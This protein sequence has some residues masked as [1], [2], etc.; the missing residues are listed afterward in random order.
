MINKLSN[1]SY[2]E[3][4]IHFILQ[5]SSVIVIIVV[6]V[7]VK[8]NFYSLKFFY[9][10]SKKKRKSRHLRFCFSLFCSCCCV[11]CGGNWGRGRGPKN[12]TIHQLARFKKIIKVQFWMFEYYVKILFFQFIFIF[13]P[14]LSTSYFFHLQTF[15]FS[16]LLLYFRL[17][18][19]LLILLC[20]LPESTVYACFADIITYMKQSP[21]ISVPPTDY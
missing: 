21:H 13:P 18:A 10:T 11:G 20:V 3:I 15:F 14:F 6:I 9:R 1:R 17:Y 2:V 16:Y 5:S 4:Y 7:I 19:R 12:R 8:M